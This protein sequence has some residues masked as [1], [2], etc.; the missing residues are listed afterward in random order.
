MLVT[1]DKFFPAI[2]LV[3]KPT[4]NVQEV[5]LWC[6][7]YERQPAI[8]AEACRAICSLSLRSDRVISIL[9]DRLVVEEDSMVLRYLSVSNFYKLVSNCPILKGG[10]LTH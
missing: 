4:D 10:G 5:L 1:C 2:G 6:L 3:A 7:R 8:R 9:Q